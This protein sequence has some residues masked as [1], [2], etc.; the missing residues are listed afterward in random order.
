MQILHF[1]LPAI[2]PAIG[3][4]LGVVLPQPPDAAL[5]TSILSFVRSCE[6]AHKCLGTIESLIAIAIPAELSWSI[7]D[8][9]S[10]TVVPSGTT[11]CSS[12]IWIVISNKNYWIFYLKL[13][14][15]SLKSSV[16]IS[17]S[18]LP[19]QVQWV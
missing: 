3:E 9:T 7:D 5:M 17:L 18:A 14:E 4:G 16:R 13:W 12:L 8:T 19:D 10:F 2:Y 11:F 1:L 6:D 15:G